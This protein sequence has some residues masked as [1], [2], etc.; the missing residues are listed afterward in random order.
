MR[1]MLTILLLTMA[2]SS[3]AQQNPIVKSTYF[4]GAEVTREHA[5]FGTVTFAGR[6]VATIN[7]GFAHG[8]KKFDQ[9]FICR[10]QES[11]IVPIG[12]LTIKQTK[13]ETSYGTLSAAFRVKPTD[14]AVIPAKELDIWTQK[15]RLTIASRE[16]LIRR[17]RSNRY[18][19][20]EFSLSLNRELADDYVKTER[21]QVDGVLGSF[22]IKSEH[23]KVEFEKK[24]GTEKPPSE[25]IV[26]GLTTEEG[27]SALLRAGFLRY[28]DQVTYEDGP[29]VTSEDLAG[30]PLDPRN[31]T[32]N[33]GLVARRH[34]ETLNAVAKRM[35]A[36]KKAS[37][38]YVP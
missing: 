37:V 36:I 10:R 30:I 28:L 24:T 17:M 16:E 8:V 33:P 3:S 11:L 2:T 6:T 38:S 27:E 31:G 5:I 35:F 20:R 1:A 29:Q 22:E 7:L 26:E 32:S 25:Q 34:L 14:Y 4:R 18:D 21:E 15:S 19:T 23:F 9:F 13:P 12:I